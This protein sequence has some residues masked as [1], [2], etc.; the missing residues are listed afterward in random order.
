MMSIALIAALNETRK[1]LLIQWSYR[2]NLIGEILTIGFVFIGIIFFMGNGKLDA[3][4]LPSSLL[5]FVIWFY[6]AIAIGNMAWGLRE[7]MQSGTLEQ[8]YMSPAP[9]SLITLGRTLATLVTSTVVVTLVAAPLMLLLKIH[10]PF[11][12]NGLPIFA[13]TM[14]GLY[15]FGFLVGG[16]VLIFKQVETLANMVSNML[17]FLNGAF[18]PVDHLPRWLEVIART[19]PSTQGIIVLRR[20]MLEGQTLA[21]V[22]HDGSLPWL[23]LHSTLYF[24]GGL[25]VF[26]LCERIARQRGSLGQ[27]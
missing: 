26:A 20:V 6:A 17:L 3:A 19:L 25:A 5:G 18:L 22:W 2:F 24:F 4:S 1:G 23:I 21:M 11:S 10:L 15:G 12:W 7:E 8:M 9:A 16:A 14:A 13:L 27:Y